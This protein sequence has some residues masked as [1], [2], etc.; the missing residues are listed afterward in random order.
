MANAD[1]IFSRSGSKVNY[2]G[3]TEDAPKYFQQRM[4]SQQAKKRNNSYFDGV[5][6]RTND[7]LG[8]ISKQ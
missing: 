3:N 2:Q 5:V 6:R 8:E 4:S 1:E 7:P